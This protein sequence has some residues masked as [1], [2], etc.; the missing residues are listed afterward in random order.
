MVLLLFSAD[1]LVRYG[2]NQPQSDTRL[3]D[4]VALRSRQGV[5]KHNIYCRQCLIKK[6]QSPESVALLS[7]QAV[8]SDLVLES[9]EKAASMR[10]PSRR[11]KL[12]KP[13]DMSARHP[14]QQSHSSRRQHNCQCLVLLGVLLL[15]LLPYA[16]G[17]HVHVN[18]QMRDH[19]H[20]VE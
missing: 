2:A 16:S 12:S 3:P 19:L 13:P 6:R 4:A 18:K 9:L 5:A 10:Q 1:N 17:A 14:D 11:T 15:G 7:L 8:L 20:Q